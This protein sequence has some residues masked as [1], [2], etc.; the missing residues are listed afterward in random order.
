VLC[1]V[2][3]CVF[4][5]VCCPVRAALKSNPYLCMSAPVGTGYQEVV[6]AQC[7]ASDATQVRGCR[8][9]YTLRLPSRT[10]NRRV[11]ALA[12]V[13]KVGL[14]GLPLHCHS[15][16][17]DESAGWGCVDAGVAVVVIVVQLLGAVA[18]AFSVYCSPL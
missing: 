2:M 10:T 16:A 3:C 8:C 17:S 6:L 12:G 7:N 14:H 9:A 11:M 4:C 18:P 15:V 1:V 5:V 13:L